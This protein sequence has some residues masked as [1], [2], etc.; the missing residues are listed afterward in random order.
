[1]N[2]VDGIAVVL[3]FGVV[4][5]VGLWQRRRTVDTLESHFLGERRIPWLLLAISG[6]VSNFDLT[7]TMWIV[8]ILY[9]LGMQSWWQHWM[10]GVALPAFGMAYMA[11]WVR[12]SSAMTGA[13]WMIT[14]FGDGAAGRA[15]RYAYASVAVLFTVGSVAYALQGMIKFAD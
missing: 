14:R 9:A 2:A 4:I 3:Y 1:M 10:W 12:R 13:D 15:A 11:K 7:G 6:A 5:G 8:S